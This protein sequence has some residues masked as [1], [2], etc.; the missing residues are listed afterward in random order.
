VSGRDDGGD[1]G[2][3]EWLDW[4]S[5]RGAPIAVASCFAFVHRVSSLE[6]F[7][8]AKLRDIHVAD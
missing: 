4:D 2:Q 8:L 3:F 5:R 1:V 7:E 6:Q